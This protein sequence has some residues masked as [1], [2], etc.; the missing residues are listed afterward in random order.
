[1]GLLLHLPLP[2]GRFR[3]PQVGSR[4]DPE[5]LLG[6]TCRHT[7]DHSQVDQIVR[8]LVL[9]RACVGI[10]PLDG[11]PVHTPEPGIH[12]PRREAD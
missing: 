4:E 2:L 8:P 9:L 1:M 3:D 7:S 10:L 12:H 5:D 6:Y 11:D